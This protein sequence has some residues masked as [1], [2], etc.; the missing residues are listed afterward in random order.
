MGE[1]GEDCLKEDMMED[2][3]E[4]VSEKDS[5]VTNSSSSFCLALVVYPPASPCGVWEA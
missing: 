4:E 5:H 3:K 1:A 2:M